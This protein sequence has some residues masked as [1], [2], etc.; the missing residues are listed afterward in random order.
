M[1]SSDLRYP[2]GKFAYQP[3]T[4][5]SQR[6][7]QIIA[8]EKTPTSLRGALHDLSDPQLDTAYRPGGWTVRQLV[9]HI[10]DSHIN[11]YVRF[12]LALTEDAPPIKSYD[13]AKWA[14]LDDARTMPVDVSLALLDSL[15]RRWVHLLRSMSDDDF[16]RELVHSENG[17]MT[18]ER[19]LAL[20]A[21]HGDHHVAHIT[22][23]REREGWE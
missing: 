5:P 8:I 14:E 17:P 7:A 16:K 6:S 2:I 19:M 22:R 10:A 11:S 23:L 15:H 13:E 18:L 12:R 3:T 20:Y 9:H 21:W 4:S 1:P